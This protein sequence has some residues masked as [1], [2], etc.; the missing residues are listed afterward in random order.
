LGEKSI[1]KLILKWDGGVIY[2][3]VVYFG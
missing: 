2:Y 3:W 1:V